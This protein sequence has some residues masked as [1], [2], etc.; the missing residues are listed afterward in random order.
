MN[1]LPGTCARDTPTEKSPGAQIRREAP[2]KTPS[3]TQTSRSAP[4]ISRQLKITT[5]WFVGFFCDSHTGCTPSTVITRIEWRYLEGPATQGTPPA[6]PG[7]GASVHPK[8]KGIERIR[9]S[10]H[11]P[12]DGTGDILV[13]YDDGQEDMVG[14]VSRTEVGSRSGK[15]W[16]ADLWDAH[17][18]LAEGH[19]TWKR[20]ARELGDCLTGSVRAT[21]PWW[22]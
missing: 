13:V 10:L 20:T 14:S 7:T 8:A 17:P 22:E 5:S 16:K 1:G 3:T 12:A 6:R 19:V 9:V 21:G 2:S 4:W 11:R 15:G 18:S